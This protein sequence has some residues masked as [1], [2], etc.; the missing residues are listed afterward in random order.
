MKS[1]LFSICV[2]C[3]ICGSISAA[4]TLTHL[5]PAGGQ[6]GTTV[7]VTAAGAFDK[8]PVSV[9]VSGGGISATATKDKGKLTVT[10]PP[11]ADLG[12]YW[13]RLHDETGASTLRPFVV[14][15]LPEMIETEPNDDAAK[16]QVMA[17]SCVVNGQLQKA[18]D[19]DC[20]A[21]TLTKG[22]TL[23]AA[24]DADRTLKSPM[25]AV[26]QIVSADGFV[27]DQSNDHHG[28]DPFL[29]FTAPRDGTY[30]ARVFAFP[31]TPD[32]SI[33]FAGGDAFVYRLTLTTG[34][35]GDHPWPLAVSREQPGVAAVVGWNVPDAA[36]LLT[37]TP[38]SKPF[39]KL[40]HP[41]LANTL[42]VAVE[43]H[44]CYEAEHAM[45]RDNPFAPSVTLSGRLQKPGE[46]HRIPIMMKKGQPV[47]VKIE[48]RTIGFAL[49]PLLAVVDAGGKS[50]AKAEPKG[51]NDDAEL[52]FTPPQDGTYSIEVRDLHRGSG[53][54]YAYR[55]AI[56]KPEP[57]FTLTVPSDRIAL[58][59]GTPTDVMVTVVKKGGF[60]K[61]VTVSAEGLPAGVTATPMGASLRFTASEA[62]TPG[63]IRIVGKADV[64][65]RTATAPLA[66][67]GISVEE[68][69]LF[70]GAAPAA[71]PKKSKK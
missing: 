41:S 44:P 53:P 71:A 36:K 50:L 58:T 51:I 63:V 23:V 56:R 15:T 32:S 21:V 18:G 47:V 28:L 12:T 35:Y 42:S 10:I 24:V 55:L 14:G 16:A 30:L 34:G 5:V 67:F 9:W 57:D 60:A 49:T 3:V 69:W 29:A 52:T 25:D 4:P 40:F 38:G 7:A 27:L 31:A 39:A 54:R 22:Q 13:V 6:R 37:V 61:D 46:T 65:T 17:Q 11:K 64:G 68:L 66:E 1:V 59:P 19:V 45:K 43:P 26:L 33:R 2:I 8:W 20:F 70:A 62:F 48:A